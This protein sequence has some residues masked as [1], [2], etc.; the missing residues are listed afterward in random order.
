MG[1]KKVMPSQKRKKNAGNRRF[2]KHNDHLAGVLQD[3]GE[4][5]ASKADK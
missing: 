2:K 3:Y 4:L 1:L 5:K